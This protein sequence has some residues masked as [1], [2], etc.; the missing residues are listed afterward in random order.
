[1]IAFAIALAIIAAS[2]PPADP[3]QSEVTT[4]RQAQALVRILRAEPVRFSEI[5]DS[6]SELLRETAIRSPDGSMKPARLVEFE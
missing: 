5:E 3:L 2:Q 4:G 1:M 6:R